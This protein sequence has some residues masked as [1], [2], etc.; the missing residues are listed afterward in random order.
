MPLSKKV[1]IIDQDAQFREQLKAYFLSDSLYQFQIQE[2]P[3]ALN[4]LEKCRE[5]AQDLIVLSSATKDVV[6]NDF[7]NSFQAEGFSGAVIFLGKNDEEAQCLEAINLGAKD[8]ILASP[9][10]QPYFIHRI[11]QLFEKESLNQK[12][13]RQASTLE[14]LSIQDSL[15]QLPNRE[16]CMRIL[17]QNIAQS[18]R[19]NR[20]FGLLTINID[21]FKS[22]NESFN[23]EIGDRVLQEF[24]IRLKRAIRI[25]DVAMR[26][27][28]DEFSIILTEIKEVFDAGKAAKKIMQELKR[29]FMVCSTEMVISTSIGVACFPVAGL[30]PAVLL[31]NAGIAMHRAKQEGGN[32]YQFFQ[33]DLQDHYMQRVMLENEMLFAL[34]RKEIFLRYQ[35][36][37]DL[38]SNEII[39]MEAFIRWAHPKLGEIGPD[40]FITIAENNGQIIPIG[41]WIID[42][43]CAQFAQWLPLMNPG[44]RLCLNLSMRQLEYE[45]LPEVVGKALIANHLSSSQLEMDLPESALTSQSAAVQNNIKQ[46]HE[47]GVFIIIENFGTGLI[48]FKNL[49]NAP[50]SALKIDRCFIKDLNRNISDAAVVKSLIALG[51]SLGVSVIA[52][53]VEE[54]AQ[55]DFLLKNHCSQAQGFLFSKPLEVAEMGNLL[56]KSKK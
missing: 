29:P 9:L 45:N 48:G 50:F 15:T 32:Q 31:K 5:Q 56:Q 46:L 12:I 7:M 43:A 19:N 37:I 53:G 36:K 39:G 2:S 52:E 14:E 10:T 16:F 38:K 23:H 21:H 49:K 41:N 13:Q 47:M 4:G 40:K 51:N 27:W 33:P 24:A 25:E 28:G 35:P 34:D 54:E 44:V 8:C 3:T 42:T 18:Q 20:L 11:N 6:L 26:M 22:I 17:S 30:D 55:K 1:L